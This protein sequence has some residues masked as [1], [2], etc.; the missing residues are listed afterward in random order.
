MKIT[1]QATWQKLS[2][3]RH[4]HKDDLLKFKQIWKVVAARWA[5]LRTSETADILISHTNNSRFYREGNY[6]RSQEEADR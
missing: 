2:A 3:F 4:V 6:Q 1:N 5:T